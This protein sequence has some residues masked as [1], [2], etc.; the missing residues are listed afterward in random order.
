LQGQ[1]RRIVSTLAPLVGA[2]R[3]REGG[4]VNKRITGGSLSLSAGVVG[5]TVD[6]RRGGGDDADT[7]RRVLLFLEDRRILWAE[8][9]AEDEAHCIAS[10]IQIRH[11][12]TRELQQKTLSAGMIGCLKAIRAACREFVD[13]A[14]PEGRNFW[15][16]HG[17]DAHPFA[18]ALGRLKALVG[19]QL[20]LIVR[21]FH[22]DV[23]PQLARALPPAPSE[24]DAGGVEE[25][26]RWLTS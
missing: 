7:A 26:R 10:A 21:E 20:A 15:H 5:V 23:E 1:D 9:V 4:W 25:L 14:G 12:L 13:S 6:F 22:L 24:E 19:V 16:A 18:L 2:E 17:C 3:T 11:E 8:R